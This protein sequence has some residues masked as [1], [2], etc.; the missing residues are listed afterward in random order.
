MRRL[1]DRQLERA[2]CSLDSP[3]DQQAWS[4]FLGCV[5][6]AYEEAEHD[7]YLV[8]R[9]IEISSQEMRSLH[10]MLA[11]ERDAIST[12][13]R[14]LAEGVCA[15]NCDGEVLL[16]NPAGRQLL[17]V[18]Q[19]ETTLIGRHISDVVDLR[20]EDG[21]SI[22]VLLSEVKR[23]DD[24]GFRLI[25]GG[26]TDVHLVCSL[27]PLAGGHGG[28]VLTLRDETLRVRHEAEVVEL[29]RRLVDLGRRAGMAEVASGVLHNVGNVLNSV[30]VSAGIVRE[31]LRKLRL[32]GLEKACALLCAHDD[33][34][35]EFLTRDETG[36]RLPSYFS[37]VAKHLASEQHEMQAELDLLAKYVE[38]IN[39]IITVQQAHVGV[40]GPK[41]RETIESLVEDALAITLSDFNRHGIRVSKDFADVPG[42]WTDRSQVLQILVNLLTNAKDAL[43][44]NAEGDRK[45]YIS[46]RQLELPHSAVRIEIR[47]N[48]KGIAPEHLT[49]VFCLGF[50]TRPGGHG[51][52]LHTAATAA[53]AMRA[54]LTAASDGVGLGAAFALDVPIEC[55]QEG[56][57]A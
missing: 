56:L 12:V 45:I 16:I 24:A 43:R 49:Q 39:E 51:I 47:D 9:S 44:G 23:I 26:N 53:M 7:R 54:R 32:S 48:G 18:D 1:L 3:P 14:S 10:Q 22:E 52:G 21:I 35:C 20:N 28:F 55:V 27:R 25:A 40:T 8:E 4:A 34:L 41:E 2:R 57:A 6:R 29:N 30:N 15:L 5:A 13:I 36:S 11:A 50:T 33:D 42:V 17:G 46:I 38:H 19:S 31:R 37:E